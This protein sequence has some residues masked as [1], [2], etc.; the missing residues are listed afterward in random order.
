M[1][2]EVLCDD[3]LGDSAVLATLSE[4]L[5]GR[6]LLPNEGK[7]DS[8]TAAAQTRVA[9]LVTSLTRYGYRLAP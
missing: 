4:L 1:C 5:H 6:P 7:G 3:Y 2:V 9:V 8:V